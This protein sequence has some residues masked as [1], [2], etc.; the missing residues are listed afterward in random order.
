MS[1]RMM[2][3]KA[4]LTTKDSQRRKQGTRKAVHK[5]W[6][7]DKQTSGSWSRSD[8]LAWA[9]EKGEQRAIADRPKRVSGWRLPSRTGV[10]PDDRKLARS[11][12]DWNLNEVALKECRRAPFWP[13]VTAA[14]DEDGG[15]LQDE[16]IEAFAGAYDRYV[17]SQIQRG[18]DRHRRPHG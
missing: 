6:T 12:D 2:L 16:V 9:R 18:G 15:L 17:D 10:R 4:L 13:Q 7:G 5:M 14:V 8:M 1:V 3:L 11:L